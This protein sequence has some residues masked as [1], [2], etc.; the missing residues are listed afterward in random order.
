MW[1]IPTEYVMLEKN[2]KKLIFILGESDLK[3][4]QNLYICDYMYIV[5]KGKANFIKFFST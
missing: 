4:Y 5:I 3:Q 2:P 1:D